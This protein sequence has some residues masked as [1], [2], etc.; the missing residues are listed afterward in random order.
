MIF[1]LSSPKKMFGQSCVCVCVLKCG[2]MSFSGVVLCKNDGNRY[3]EKKKTIN[4]TYRQKKMDEAV[5]E[6]K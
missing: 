3:D 1:L 4:N 5:N 6:R 2:P